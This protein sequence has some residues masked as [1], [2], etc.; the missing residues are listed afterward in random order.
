MADL[1]LEI[2]S[3][4]IPAR[5]QRRAAQD[6]HDLIVKALADHGVAPGASGHDATPRRLIVTVAGLPARQEDLEEERK[7]PRV[8]APDKAVE[9]FARSAGVEVAALEQR[10]TDKGPCWFAVVRREGRAWARCSPTCCPPP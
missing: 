8:G 4:E 2:L 9:G 3:E 10:D 6:L 5:M 7:G 1:L